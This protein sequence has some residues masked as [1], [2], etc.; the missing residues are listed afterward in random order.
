MRAVWKFYDFFTRRR[1][2]QSFVVFGGPD[3]EKNLSK[4]DLYEQA[5]PDAN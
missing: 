3:T 5:E 1:I 2:K 4:D